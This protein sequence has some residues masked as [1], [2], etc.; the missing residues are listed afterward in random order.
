MCNRKGSRDVAYPDL[1]PVHQHTDHVEPVLLEWMAM[2]IDP[3]LGGLRQLLLLPP[4]HR[5][6]RPAEVTPSAR[7]Y[8]DERHHAILFDNKVD[9]PMAVP[10]A[11]VDHLPTASP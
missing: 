3:D 7:F 5:G 4:I 1:S 9:V 11:S 8:L 2:A 10:K 6:N